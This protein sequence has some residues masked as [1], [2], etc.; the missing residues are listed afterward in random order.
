MSAKVRCWM[1]ISPNGY[2]SKLD[3]NE[4]WIDEVN[5]DD[6]VSGSKKVSNFVVGRTT[7][8]V[9]SELDEVDVK[10]KVV[11]SHQKGLKLREGYKIVN[12]PREAVEYLQTQ[13]VK[14]ILLAGGGGL[15]ASFLAA[16][17]IDELDLYLEPFVIGDGKRVLAAGNYEAPL[18]LIKIEKLSHGRARVVYKVSQTRGGL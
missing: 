5:W 7:Y 18:E 9:V 8:E 16:G 12:S 4:D 15:N 13:G 10:H 3:G 17:L 1:V 14:E 2:I 6:F 11:V